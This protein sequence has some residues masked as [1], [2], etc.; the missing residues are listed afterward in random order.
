M[1]RLFTFAWFLFSV[2]LQPLRA[3]LRWDTRTMDLKPSPTDLVAEAK[4]GFLNAGKSEVTIESVKSS[5]GCTVPTLAKTA[6]APGERG[7]VTARF[8]IGDRRGAQSATIRV[9]VK[10]ERDPVTLTL[11]VTIPEVAKLT[12]PMLMW[13]PGEKP[14]E[15]TFE[16]SAVSNQPMRVVKVTSS[17]PDFEVR[18]ET[19]EE[20]AKYRVVVKPGSTERQGFAV[21]NIET[22]I[23]EGVKVLRA[24]AQV[25]SNTQAGPGAKGTSMPALPPRPATMAEL[26]PALL[27][28]DQGAAPAAKT[29]SVRASAGGTVNVSKV[30]PSTA[31]F[32]ATV[33]TVKESN[34]YR[35]TVTP[36]STGKP[37]LA[38]LNIEVNSGS[39]PAIQHAYVQIAGPA[40]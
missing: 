32:D 14:E 30:T 2:A 29:I 36:K 33:E 39:G 35:I 26:E 21:L 31:N 17:A 16:V 18:V 8:N 4:F 22:K 23:Q 20:A 34:E 28:W 38:F 9:S 6:Y 15:K 10:G 5:C 13:S 11:N 24:Y 7:E 19:V 3:E 25:R 12:P 1:L 40:K 27:A 37:E